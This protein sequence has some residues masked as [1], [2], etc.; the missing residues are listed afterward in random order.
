VPFS[1]LSRLPLDHVDLGRCLRLIDEIK[2]TNV[3]ILAAPSAEL[4]TLRPGI[5]TLRKP[6]IHRKAERV[7]SNWKAPYSAD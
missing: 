6:L 5:E 1:N 3:L 2:L 7:L 4:P